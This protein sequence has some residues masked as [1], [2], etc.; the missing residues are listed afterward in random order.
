MLLVRIRLKKDTGLLW[1]N[2]FSRHCTMGNNLCS[3]VLFAFPPIGSVTSERIEI[4]SD[5]YKVPEPLRADPYS[6]L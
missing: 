5:R 6:V 2:M 3:D 1:I 4:Y